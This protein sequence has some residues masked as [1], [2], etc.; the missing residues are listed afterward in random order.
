MSGAA[1][2]AGLFV[3]ADPATHRATKRLA[4]RP[5]PGQVGGRT[6]VR[7]AERLV[8][9]AD[10]AA[11]TTELRLFAVD[12]FGNVADAPIGGFDVELTATGGVSIIAPDGNGDTS[13]ETLSITDSTGITI[14]VDDAGSGAGRLLVH[15][16]A[17]L[18]HVTETVTGT[19]ADTDGDG[20]LDDGDGSGLAGDNTCTPDDVPFAACDDNCP[21]TGNADQ[22]DEDA[23]GFGS[24][25]DGTCQADP[26]RDGC[27]ICVAGPT[28]PVADK[29]KLKGK[30][31]DA[32]KSEKLGLKMDFRL[33]VGA[34][35][36]PTTESVTVS[37]IQNS[38]EA[39]GATLTG[40]F[41]QLG[42]KRSSFSYKDKDRT[43]A[44]L[45]KVR[46]KERSGG[47]WRASWKAAGTDLLDLD[48]STVTISVTLGDDQL[49]KTTPCSGNTRSVGCKSD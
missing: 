20:V 4:L 43:I 46:I 36:D 44:G 37:V 35:I 39:Y 8:L 7:R 19:G 42:G 32:P 29:T 13:T 5:A 14:T 6:L 15:A 48:T 45:S 34:S 33:A 21:L 25:C 31:A 18:V 28:A 16:G 1:S 17:T 30:L 40:A 10:G 49:T 41:D 38:V 2:A 23:D 9:A 22:A 12:L 11:T 24:C 26:L 47:R 27:D 3:E